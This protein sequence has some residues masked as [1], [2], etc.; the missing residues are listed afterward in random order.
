MGAALM[1]IGGIGGP[2]TM[3]SLTAQLLDNEPAHGT[4]VVGDIALRETA[5]VDR[6]EHVTDTEYGGRR[7][8]T[9][10]A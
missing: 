3:P 10:T 6:P 1:V 5:D 2:L 9:R 7:R 4:G 8:S